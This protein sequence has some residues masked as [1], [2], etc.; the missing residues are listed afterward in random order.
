MQSTRTPDHIRT[1]DR[2]HAEENTQGQD[3]TNTDHLADHY[4]D[5]H[6]TDDAQTHRA[7]TA[8]VTHTQQRPAGRDAVITD[9][10]QLTEGQVRVDNETNDHRLE[11]EERDK[12]KDTNMEPM[13]REE[14]A[15]ALRWV[16]CMRAVCKFKLM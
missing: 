15:D 7:A 1:A 16:C 2:C 4:T 6:A 8:E 10:I 12:K 3:Q 5:T 13:E 11:D 14:S 9:K